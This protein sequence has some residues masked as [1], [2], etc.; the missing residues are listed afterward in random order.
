MFQQLLQIQDTQITKSKLMKK[1]IL[2]SL[3]FLGSVMISQAQVKPE[4]GTVGLGFRI[5]GLF[6]VGLFN[7]QNTGLNGAPFMDPTPSGAFAGIATV[8]QLVPQEMMFGR[9]YVTSDIAIRAGLGINSVNAKMNTVDSVGTDILTAESKVSAFSFGV[10]AGV[11]KHFATAAGKIDPYVG[12]QVDL[13]M[14]G[15]L[16]SETNTDITS[17]PIVTTNDMTELDGGMSFGVNALAGF[18]YFF[19]DNFALGA[20]FSWGFN[21]LSV[22]GD[23]TETNSATVGGNTTTTKAI[24]TSKFSASGLRVGSTSGVN[25]SIFF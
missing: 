13:G 15:K 18:N 7:F 1:V 11:E 17:D 21:S 6:N 8:D 12:A 23:W 24:G 16:K 20:E 2:L 9:Y 5:T 4:A 25:A 22:G 3:I 10:S 19:T 14:L